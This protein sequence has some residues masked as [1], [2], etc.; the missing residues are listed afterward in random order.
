LL[1]C[2]EKGERKR[3]SRGWKI[4]REEAKAKTESLTTEASKELGSP[5]KGPWGGGVVHRRLTVGGA[6]THSARV[7]TG[8][9]TEAG[10][11]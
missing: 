3:D 5:K 10:E 8:G 6:D 9:G 7:R 1:L 2:R 11:D 4:L